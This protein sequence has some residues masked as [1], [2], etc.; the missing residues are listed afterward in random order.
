LAVR[1]EPINALLVTHVTAIIIFFYIFCNALWIF[2][3]IS[4]H[5][6]D[7]KFICEEVL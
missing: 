7:S 5:K 1:D 3:V 2:M 6:R 4:F